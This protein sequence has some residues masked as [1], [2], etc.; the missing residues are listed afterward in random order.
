MLEKALYMLCRISPNCKRF[1]WRSWYD[2]IIS[3][4]RKASFLFMNYGYVETSPD[5]PPLPLEAAEENYRH[6]IQLYHHVAK[7]VDMTG[8]EVLEV[9]CGCGGGAAYIA[10]NFGPA[11]MKGLDYSQRAI[12]ACKKYHAAAPNLSFVHGDAQAL[13]FDAGSFDI[14]VNV[15]SSH[16]YPNQGRFFGEV[17]RILRP[18][19]WFLIADFRNKQVIPALRQQLCDARLQ[20][21][22]EENIT[23]NILKSLESSHDRKVKSIPPGVFQQFFHKFSATKDSTTFKKF[24]S[25]ETE[26]FF[27][28]LQ[29]GK[30]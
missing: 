3:Y 26:Y 10:T 1:L 19:G 25:G 11:I 17:S 13:P 20:L 4:D 23:P 22:R 5:A 29:K 12:E 18:Q 15:E 9:G 28:V 16:T 24:E 21:Q 2:Y 8:K 30:G 7:A 14:V 27:F 6:R